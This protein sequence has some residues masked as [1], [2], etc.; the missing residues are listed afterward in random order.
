MDDQICKTF[1]VL[2]EGGGL[3]TTIIHVA[4]KIKWFYCDIES[5]PV[6]SYLFASLFKKVLAEDLLNTNKHM[7]MKKDTRKRQYV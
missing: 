2:D 7:S 6:R 1:L 4:Q 5:C 3:M